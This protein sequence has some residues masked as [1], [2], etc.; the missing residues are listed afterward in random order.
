MIYFFLHCLLF[1]IFLVNFHLIWHLRYTKRERGRICA[2][3]A[4]RHIL[5]VNLRGGEWLGYLALYTFLIPSEPQHSNLYDG[6]KTRFFF[7][8][9]CELY[10]FCVSF[11]AFAFLTKEKQQRMRRF[12]KPVVTASQEA[13][14]WGKTGVGKTCLTVGSPAL[15]QQKDISPPLSYP[16][17]WTKIAFNLHR[18]AEWE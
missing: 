17:C 11:R 10:K 7:L 9:L 14:C 15:G 3:E 16:V 6:W 1:L 12:A 18:Y 2:R 4:A 8:S 13:V 5:V